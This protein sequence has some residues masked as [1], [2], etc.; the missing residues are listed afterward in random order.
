MTVVGQADGLHTAGVKVEVW[1]FSR[2]RSEPK[3]SKT[4][5]RA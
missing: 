4:R 5:A 3:H 2:F 1:S